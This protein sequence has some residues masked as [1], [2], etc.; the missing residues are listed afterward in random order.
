[1]ASEGAGI[2]MRVYGLL[3]SLVY[4][5]FVQCMG[6]KLCKLGER[7]LKQGLDA[8]QPRLTTCDVFP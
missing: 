7:K 4:G 5:L 3:C 2:R 1:M 6:C 8:Q